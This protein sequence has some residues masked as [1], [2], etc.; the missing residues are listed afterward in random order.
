MTTKE[1]V[2]LNTWLFDDNR[3]EFNYP[4]KVLVAEGT[5]I[6]S[7]N[8]HT[9]VGENTDDILIDH[10]GGSDTLVGN[11]G[12]DYL[13]GGAGA[14]TLVGGSGEDTYIATNGDS[15]YD[16]DGKGTVNFEGFLLKGGTAV[17]G[18]SG[19]Y[20]GESGETYT[21]DA[22]NNLYVAKTNI[23]YIKLREI[24]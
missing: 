11:A 15:I 1:V 2:A 23:Q 16:S 4:T 14:D 6:Y 19:V 7:D 18:Q 22:N 8:D 9:L 21:L 24:I 20:K 17:E 13:D 10:N 3:I 12:N 5:S